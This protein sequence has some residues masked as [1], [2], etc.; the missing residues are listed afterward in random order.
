MKIE[1]LVQ[2]IDILLFLSENDKIELRVISEKFN[3]SYQTVH[4]LIEKWK[5]E[6]YVERKRKEVLFLGGD[7]YEYTITDKGK[8][9]IKDLKEKISKI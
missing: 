6:G 7:K 9:V 4:S 3:L 5:D 8:K 2:Y 1:K